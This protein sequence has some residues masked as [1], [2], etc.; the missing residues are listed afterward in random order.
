M[1]GPYEPERG[2]RFNHNKVVLDPYAKAVGRTVHRCEEMYGYSVGDAQEDLSFDDRDNAASCALGAVIDSA[3]SWGDD[4]P[5]SRGSN[6]AAPKMSDRAWSASSMLGLGVRLLGTEI[7]ETDENGDRIIGDTLFMAFNA[8]HEAMRF[9]LPDT[10][11]LHWETV[12]DT[13]RNDWGWRASLDGSRYAL[14]AR[15][16]AVFRT[17]GAKSAGDTT[18]LG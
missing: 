3:F 1:H 2:H 16:V 6:R 15:S 12:L 13:S 4:R 17:D 9:V 5:P 18:N 10:P 8:H 11:G 14:P 7:E